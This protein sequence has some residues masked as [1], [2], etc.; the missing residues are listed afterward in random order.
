MLRSFKTF[1]EGKKID[2]KKAKRAVFTFIRANP[3]TRGHSKV[4][5]KVHQVAGNDKHFIFLSQ[6]QDKTKN[7]LD[8]KTKIEFAEQL[9]GTTSNIV[10]DKKPKSPFDA[11]EWLVNKGFSD[12]VFV[13]GSDRVPEFENRMSPFAKTLVD[14]FEIVSAGERDPDAEGVVGMSATK[15][16][17]AA[18]MDDLGKF[19][20][21]TGWT[22]D[23]SLKL[24]RAVKQSM[25]SSK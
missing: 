14:N 1:C 12:I 7:P 22:G 17:E 6:K 15:A 5:E 13:V 24:M 2:T 20:V 8:W 21:S 18:K 11:L 3:P 9:F 25:E 10:T 23:I 19:R 16:R 4:V